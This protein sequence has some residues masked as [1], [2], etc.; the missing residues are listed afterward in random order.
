[1]SMARVAWVD[2]E[3]STPKI[4]PAGTVNNQYSISK[5]VPVKLDDGTMIIA[6][7]QEG[8]D[9]GEGGEEWKSWVC[10]AYGFE[11]VEDVKQW[12]IG[13]PE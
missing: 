11:I 6:Q 7:Y 5:P 12:L 10:E 8:K 13:V 3:L 2:V 1:M 4:E 9:P